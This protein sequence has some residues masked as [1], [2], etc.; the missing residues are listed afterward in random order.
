MLLA[1]VIAPMQLSFATM[2]A[3]S[4]G[5]DSTAANPRNGSYQDA[6]IIGLAVDAQ[7]A[8]DGARV[9]QYLREHVEAIYEPIGGR[10]PLDSDFF[11]LT[12]YSLAWDAHP[13]LT[14]HT[15]A[16]YAIGSPILF[17]SRAGR[18]DVS[19]SRSGLAFPHQVIATYSL[20]QEMSA[21]L[22]E[23]ETFQIEAAV[24]GQ[25][26]VTRQPRG[27]NMFTPYA[28]TR[29]THE[30]NPE[31]YGDAS[32]VVQYLDLELFRPVWLVQGFVGWMHALD[33][34]SDF[35][36]EAG[37][38]ESGVAQ[39]AA[40]WQTQP[41]VHARITKRF[42]RQRVIAG[43]SYVH[44]I[45]IV[46]ATLGTGSIDL[47]TAS[48]LW[49]PGNGRWSFFADA[50]FQYGQGFDPTGQL[51]VNATFANAVL[52]ARYA[53]N[54]WLALFARYEFQWESDVVLQATGAPDFVRHFVLTGVQLAW[55]TDA[56]ARM[57]L[58]PLEEQEALE[59]G[60]GI[61]DGEPT[62]ARVHVPEPTLDDNDLRRRTRLPGDPPEAPAVPDNAPPPPGSAAAPG[63]N[64]PDVEGPFRTDEGE[65]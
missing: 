57:T 36:L 62:G 8:Y 16:S 44:T 22:R 55:G 5:Y 6:P 32:T 48:A 20:R 56:F 7:G 31:N 11:N 14:L 58:L 63:D 49:M 65:R 12:H 2:G 27:T 37:V 61:Y 59:H 47:A 35:L 29:Y 1:Q 26:P 13:D 50:G 38:S 51:P 21:M 45:G 3:V 40:Q 28:A 9:H 42:E 19:F 52:G 4:G 18:P 53:L 30:F 64:E 10:D 33:D 24:I 60:A 17:F 46:S 25:Y 43:A 41:L 54:D 39:S 23:R 34:S 15:D